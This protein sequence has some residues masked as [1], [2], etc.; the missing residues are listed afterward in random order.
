MQFFHLSPPPLSSPL[1]NLSLSGFGAFSLVTMEK[2]FLSFFSMEMGGVLPGQILAACLS[3]G[4]IAGF[5]D[6]LGLVCVSVVRGG[7][8]GVDRGAD[9]CPLLH[10]SG[11]AAGLHL[12]PQ[13]AP[14]PHL[15]LLR[16]RRDAPPPAPE[17]HRS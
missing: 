16:S 5:S 13:Q 8:G 9:V 12:Q 4:K 7:G 11:P 14:L 3:S 15:L 17:R 10:C 2:L 1:S 6:T